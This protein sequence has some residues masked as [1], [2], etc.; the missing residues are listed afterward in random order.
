MTAS[1]IEQR[2]N[3]LESNVRFYKQIIIGLI[4]VIG[5]VAFMSFTKKAT[6][7]DVVKAKEFQVVDD[8]GRVYLSLKKDQGAGQVDLFNSSGTKLLTLTS[9]D[10]GAGTIIGRDAAG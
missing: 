9:S 1:L 6:V 2:L 8:Y 4:A 5:V 3:K 10:G 7:E